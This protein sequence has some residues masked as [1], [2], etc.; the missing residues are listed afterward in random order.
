MIRPSGACPVSI[1]GSSG[2][3]HA[4]SVASKT[5]PSRLE[6]TSSGHMMR[7][8]RSSSLR[9]KTSAYH[10]PSCISALPLVWPGV[11]DVER[12][13]VQV[14]QLQV[15]AQLAAVDVRVRA[16]AQ[17]A[18]RARVDDLRD[19][20]AVLVEQV[21]RA[22]GAQ[23]VLE[24]L[25]VPGIG[26][27]LHRRH[28][29]RLRGALDL[30]AVDLLRAG[31]ALRRLEHDHR[32]ARAL[33]PLAAAAHRLLQ[34]AD[35]AVRG[36]ERRGQLGVELVG[37]AVDDQRVPAVALEELRQ[38]LV[39]HRLV[40]R[41]VGDL[42]AVQVQDREHRAGGRRVEELVASARRRRSGPS[43]PR[44]RRR[45][46]RRSGPG[47]RARRRRR[48]RARSPARRPRGS[49]RAR[50][51]RRGSGSR[52]ARRSRGSASPGPRGRASAR[53]RRPRG[54]RRSRGSRGSRARRG[55]GP[56]SSRMLACVSRISRLSPA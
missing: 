52:P 41:R 6:A 16:H 21:L 20:A 13:L 29:V 32:P 31:P 45:S 53:G 39:R 51:A 19:R 35:L 56:V 34:L 38:L 2:H 9:R 8:L 24:D 26:L 55:P 15:L 22:V 48:S 37:R 47:C 40:D 17:V 3:S 25:Q 18:R 1:S 10:S 4:W 14:G 11:G 12:V 46:P 23:P 5:A 7:K 36:V 27:R 30:D 50:S 33:G 42:V 49:C 28:L 54:S 44:R 43:R